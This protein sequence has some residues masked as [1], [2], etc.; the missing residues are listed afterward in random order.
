M[1]NMFFFNKNLSKLCTEGAIQNLLS[2]LHFLT[3]DMNILGESATSDLLTLMT[4]LNESYAPK[5]VLKPS[6]G[7]DLIQKCLWI[8]HK[9]FNIQTT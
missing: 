9:K 5:A 2:M 7:I 4:S 8:S 6:L 1:K 3:E